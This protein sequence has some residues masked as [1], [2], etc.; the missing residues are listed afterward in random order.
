MLS[1]GGKNYLYG[2]NCRGTN[3][4]TR[5]NRDRNGDG[6]GA[7]ENAWLHREPEDMSDKEGG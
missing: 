5:R 4:R 3:S 6:D 7:D 1:F 2:R